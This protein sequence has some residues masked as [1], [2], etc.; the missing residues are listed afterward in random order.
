MSITKEYKDEVTIKHQDDKPWGHTAVR[1]GGGAHVIAL[2]DKTVPHIVTMLDYG[3]G[4]GTLRA[5]IEHERPGRVEITEYDPGMPGINKLPERTFDLVVTTDVLEHVE[6]H[7]LKET[8]REIAELADITVYHNIPCYAT[9]S[10]FISGPYKGMNIHLTVENPAFWKR[11]VRDNMPGFT[12]STVVTVETN[13]KRGW[14]E[15]VM[16]T[17]E[18]TEARRKTK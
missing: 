14:Q 10:S 12:I 6:P 11:I 18:R 5:H 8:I 2:L 13:K 1:F 4:E 16:I 17:T 3:S 15:R 7:L 9:G